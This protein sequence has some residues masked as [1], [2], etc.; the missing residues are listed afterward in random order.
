MTDRWANTKS[1]I[2]NDKKPGTGLEIHYKEG[3]SQNFGPDLAS[4]RVTLLEHMDTTNEKLL[5]SNPKPG[6]G[7]RCDECRKLKSMED[8]WICRMGSYHGVHG[9][10]DRNEI[11]NK[12]RG[13]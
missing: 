10:N 9:L 6:P 5:H 2:N 7:C 3:C 13:Q 4:V 8:K 11:T 12:V 1:K